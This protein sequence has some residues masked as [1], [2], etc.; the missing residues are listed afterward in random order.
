MNDFYLPS[1][2]VNKTNQEEVTHVWLQ[3]STPSEVDY[4]SL[5][6]FPPPFSHP[7]SPFSSLSDSLSIFDDIFEPLSPTTSSPDSSFSSSISFSE[8]EENECS[9]PKRQKCH[10]V[11]VETTPICD[12]EL[13]SEMT[14]VGT[15]Q[16]HIRVI[17]DSLDKLQVTLAQMKQEQGKKITLKL[18]SSSFVSYFSG[19]YSSITKQL[20]EIQTELEEIDA[21]I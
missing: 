18:V 11:I 4:L 5:S 13:F 21:Q 14:C 19:R 8:E 20:N 6:E 2:E 16:G 12:T 10:K 3:N 15:S 9:A 1:Q 7:Q 17:N